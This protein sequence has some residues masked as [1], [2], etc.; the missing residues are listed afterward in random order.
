MSPIIAAVL[1]HTDQALRDSD[2]LLRGLAE[3]RDDTQRAIDQSQAA[4]NT[5]AQLMHAIAA[6]SLLR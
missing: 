5:S 3:A 1:H 2:R 4:L 6:T